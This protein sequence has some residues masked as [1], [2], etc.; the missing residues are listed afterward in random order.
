MSGLVS[1]IASMYQGCVMEPAAWHDQMFVDWSEAVAANHELD[2]IVAK[3]VRR[4][5]AIGRRLATFWAA[6][7][8]DAAPPEWRS[9]V[10]VALGPR[11]WRPMLLVAEQV[12]ERNRDEETF[13]QVVEL[14]AVVNNQPFLDGVTYDE[15]R[16]DPELL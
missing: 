11:A 8:T 1:D 7:D 3:G 9:R 13:D 16:D 5:V 14:F 10:D 2:R 15:W 12:L 4:S 6:A